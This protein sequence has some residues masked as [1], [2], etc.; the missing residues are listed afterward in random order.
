M[1]EWV[2]NTRSNPLNL[3]LGVRV[4]LVED[5]YPDPYPG[6]P[7]LLPAGVYPTCD[8]PQVCR[9]CTHRGN[10][11]TQTHP[12][13]ITTKKRRVKMTYDMEEVME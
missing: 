9:S 11:R 4:W 1:A 13:T 6:L 5:L 7:C 2:P 3:L 10:R 12:W 8:N